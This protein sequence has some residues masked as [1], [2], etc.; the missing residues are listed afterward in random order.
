M[1]TCRLRN[2]R[3]ISGILLATAEHTMQTE[4]SII[5]LLCSLEKRFG[6]KITGLNELQHFFID[7]CTVHRI[8]NFNGFF[9]YLFVDI[10]LIFYLIPCIRGFVLLLF[11]GF[12]VAVNIVFCVVFCLVSFLFFMALSL[13][14][15]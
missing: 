14:V 12:S 4:V 6:F 9:S 11:I 10:R 5:T 13:L 3:R 7:H 8:F 15:W 1:S 2:S